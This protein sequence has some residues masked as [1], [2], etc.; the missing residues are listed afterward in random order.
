MA[1]SNFHLMVSIALIGMTAALPWRQ[2]MTTQPPPPPQID[3]RKAEGLIGFLG[4]ALFPF[5]DTPGFHTCLRTLGLNLDKGAMLYGVSLLCNLIYG[6]IVIF[7]FFVFSTTQML[8][9]TAATFVVGPSIILLLLALLI[10]FVAAIALYPMTTVTALWIFCFLQFKAFQA[11]G[12]YLN[13]DVD[14]GG[15]IQAMDIVKALSK[16][17]VGKRIKV[18]DIHCMFG[19]SDAQRRS[20]M[21]RLE[22]IEAKLDDLKRGFQDKSSN[23]RGTETAG[24]VLW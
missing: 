9:A 5:L 14:H 20:I 21:A 22:A 10:F 17:K 15:R 4:E 2:P 1:M 18:D 13:L 19:S 11:I 23:K 3:S 12:L 8:A 24:S 6:G 7:G 16:T